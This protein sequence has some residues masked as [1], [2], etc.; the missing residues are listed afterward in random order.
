MNIFFSFTDPRTNDWF[1]IKSPLPG[2]T[3]IGLY[4]YF[5]LKWGPRYMADKKPFQLQKT[6]V[7]YNFIQVLVSSWLF[8]EVCSLIYVYNFFSKTNVFAS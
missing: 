3:I 1:L 4:L 7:V 2:M 8:Y 6:L 5:T